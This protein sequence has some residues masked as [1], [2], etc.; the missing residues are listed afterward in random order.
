VGILAGFS[1]CT[2]ETTTEHGQFSSPGED[3]GGGTQVDPS[4]LT[5]TQLAAVNPSAVQ[6]QNIEGLLL[7]YYLIHRTLPWQFGDLASLADIDDPLNTICPTSGQ[8][9]IYV[10]GGIPL[11]GQDKRIVVFEPTPSKDGKRWCILMSTPM[12][13]QAMWMDVLQVPES[14]FKTYLAAQAGQ[15]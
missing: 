15:G 14:A 10:R 12:P 6:L 1:G 11:P 8:Q 4:K 9:Y 13:R 2:T 5:P 7:E 3:E